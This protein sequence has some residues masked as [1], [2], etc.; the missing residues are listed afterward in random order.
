MTV[1]FAIAPPLWSQWIDVLV[2]RSS[3]ANTAGLYGV[4]PLALRLPVA[5]VLVIWAARTDRHWIVPLAA[6]LAMPVLWPN[7][8]AVAV[9]AIPLLA[10][11][12]RVEPDEPAR[13]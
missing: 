13:A 9:A 5:A 3:A 1:S 2:G 12:S 4:I 10:L 7:A 6:V 8:F 11:Q